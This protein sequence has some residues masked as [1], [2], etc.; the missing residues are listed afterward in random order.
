V[1]SEQAVREEQASAAGAAAPGLPSAP[2][3][4]RGERA[5]PGIVQKYKQ[6]IIE[7]LASR[8]PKGIYGLR[9]E[10][11]I[12]FT[13][14]GTGEVSHA[15]VV[16]SSGQPTLDEA[17]LAAVAGTRFPAPPSGLSAA[18][19]TYRIPYYFR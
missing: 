9:G 19:L 7:R 17:A 1:A 12:E 8:K 11:A 16:R 13:I 14:A 10:V 15:K 3:V 2:T 4:S 5:S 18:Q 6:D